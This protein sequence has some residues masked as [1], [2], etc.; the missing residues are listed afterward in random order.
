[1][2]FIVCSGLYGEINQYTPKLEERHERVTTKGMSTETFDIVAG[3]RCVH[4]PV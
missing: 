2:I 3:I 1:M 4:A